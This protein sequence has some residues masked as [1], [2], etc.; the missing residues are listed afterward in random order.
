MNADIWQEVDIK[1]H[2]VSKGE[3]AENSDLWREV[4]RK[5]SFKEQSNLVSK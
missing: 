4:R 1:A 5:T 3:Q 2:I